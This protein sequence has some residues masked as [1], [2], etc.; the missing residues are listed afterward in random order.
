M[1]ERNKRLTSSIS[2]SLET[3]LP[4]SIAAFAQALTSFFKH[5]LKRK[6]MVEWERFCLLA[7]LSKRWM[8]VAWLE[9]LNRSNLRSSIFWVGG[10]KLEDDTFCFLLGWLGLARITLS[11]L[12]CYWVFDILNI[13]L[14][15]IIFNAVS[16]LDWCKPTYFCVL[17]LPFF[18][19]LSTISSALVAN[20]RNHGYCCFTSQTI[21]SCLFW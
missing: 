21:Q 17:H 18:D 13:S 19:I 15:V 20:R 3:S 11:Q 14:S 12:L 4:Q 10:K 6:M 8:R 16:S 9:R 2:Q 5:Q 1:N 7:G